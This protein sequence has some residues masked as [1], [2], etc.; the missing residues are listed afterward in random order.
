VILDKRLRRLL[1][2]GIT[3]DAAVAAVW[4]GFGVAA[5]WRGF[6]VTVLAAPG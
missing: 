5:V 2:V 6:G 4:R 1:T 3:A